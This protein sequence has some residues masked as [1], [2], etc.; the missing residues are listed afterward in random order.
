MPLTM[1]FTLIFIL[2][3]SCGGW[4][5][6]T[7]LRA[8][9]AAIVPPALP[10]FAW[11]A[12]PGS[13]R[14]V[15]SVRYLLAALPARVVLTTTGARQASSQSRRE[16]AASS[17]EPAPSGAARQMARPA[18]ARAAM[19]V[20]ITEA[21]GPGQAGYVHYFTLDMPDGS[22]E[23]QVGME[24][25]DG[26][27]AWSFPAL[28]VAVSPF[29]KSGEIEVNGRVYGLQHLY[30]IRPFPDDESMRVLQRELVNRVIPWVEDGTP[31]CNPTVD[32]KYLCTSCLGFVLR[33]LFPGRS[34]AYP[35]LPAEFRNA[36]PDP[37]YT[38]H[39]LLLYLTG[40]QGL[41]TAEAR[42]K[43]IEGLA[44]PQHLREEL[45]QLALSIEPP[46]VAAETIKPPNV[47]GKSRPRAGSVSK[48]GQQRPAQGRK[49]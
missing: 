34:P 43:R 10:E 45:L 24:L 20:V 47:S 48:S 12:E 4:A 46:N 36:A 31:Y 19:P 30:G 18:V 16:V 2:A 26:R 9:P 44:L 5:H 37:Y 33:I 27:I 23:T 29:I 11:T 42:I 7:A 15:R 25:P 39:D 13:P 32:P 1:R 3:L 14:A 17:N 8:A 49:L 40:L 35:A 21:T 6:A 22:R 41:A 28:G 38:T